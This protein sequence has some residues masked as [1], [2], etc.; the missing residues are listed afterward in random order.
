MAYVDNDGVIG[1]YSTVGIVKYT[2]TPTLSINDFSYGNINA[3]TLEYI[4]T[5][6]Q[7][8]GDVG[9]KVYSYRFDV[10]DRYGNV[11]ATSGDCL[12]D[13]SADTEVYES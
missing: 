5:Y 8:D 4:G 1:Y 11:F 13:S 6:S 12:H 9:E 10:L 7:E 3:N 2:T